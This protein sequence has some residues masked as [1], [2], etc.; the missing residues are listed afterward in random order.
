MGVKHIMT[1]KRKKAFKY[2]L[3]ISQTLRVYIQV[4]YII[5][6]A[7]RFTS[8]QLIPAFKSKINSQLGHAKSK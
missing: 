6:L 8:W 1:L 5:K 7:I 3:F 2:K 4:I